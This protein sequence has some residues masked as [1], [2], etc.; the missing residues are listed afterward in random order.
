MIIT[1]KRGEN[2]REDNYKHNNQCLNS[3]NKIITILPRLHYKIS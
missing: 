3:N 1:K 2:N